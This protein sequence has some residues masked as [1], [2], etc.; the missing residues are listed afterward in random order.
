M[1]FF[2]KG[3]QSVGGA[4][5]SLPPLPPGSVGPV[6]TFSPPQARKR[7]RIYGN[8]SPSYT[9]PSRKFTFFHRSLR[10]T[11][12]Y[13]PHKT[14]EVPNKIT[15]VAAAAA[16]NQHRLPS[17]FSHTFERK[18]SHDLLFPCKLYLFCYGM[19]KLRGKC[20]CDG[21]YIFSLF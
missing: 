12:L 13:F 3:N 18:L 15:A 2:S 9:F 11:T 14:D 17:A 1:L 5:F 10:E 6:L 20:T 4:D 21:P 19:P 8:S 16:V 7:R